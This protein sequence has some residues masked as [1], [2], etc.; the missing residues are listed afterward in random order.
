M[1]NSPESEFQEAGWEPVPFPRLAR[2]LKGLGFLQDGGTWC[3]PLPVWGSPDPI[4]YV[5]EVLP[6]GVGLTAKRKIWRKGRWVD[7]RAKVDTY[8]D[9]PS[10]V[11]ALEAIIRERQG[12]PNRVSWW[13]QPKHRFPNPPTTATV[14]CTP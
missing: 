5:V 11:A 10:L 4:V 8:T 13:H 9:L 7:H 2:R 3:R 14:K 1:T 6:D 12:V